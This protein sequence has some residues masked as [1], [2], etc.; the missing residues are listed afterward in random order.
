MLIGSELPRHSTILPRAPGLSDSRTSTALIHPRAY[1]VPLIG[2]GLSEIASIRSPGHKEG[3]GVKRR[4]S[5]PVGLVE[6]AVQSRRESANQRPNSGHGLPWKEGPGIV[7][8]RLPEARKDVLSSNTSN[9]L[10]FWRLPPKST[11]ILG[12]R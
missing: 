10:T 5:S 3:L 2:G 8:R 9:T 4:V 1:C 6:Q 7:N 11:H 12:C